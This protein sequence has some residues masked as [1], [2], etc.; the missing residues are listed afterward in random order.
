M[1][2]TGSLLLG[3]IFLLDV[4]LLLPSMSGRT[5]A[6]AKE[7]PDICRHFGVLSLDELGIRA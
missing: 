7:A 6:T 2:L 1:F 5:A 4:L 3:I